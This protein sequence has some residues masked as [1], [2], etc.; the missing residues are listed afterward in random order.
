MSFQ[1]FQRQTPLTPRATTGVPNQLAAQLG[2]GLAIPLQIIS[3]T[4]VLR[5]GPAKVAQDIYICLSTPVGRRLWQPDYGS[6]LPYLIFQPYRDILNT[7]LIVATK[8]ALTAWVPQITVSQVNIDATNI[9]NNY[10]MLVIQY[11]I[12]GTNA[13]QQI[14][15]AL[16]MNDQIKVPPGTLTIGGQPLFPQ[17]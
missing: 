12:N 16:A 3:N 4:W 6:T 5:S 10:L 9:N 11:T 1:Y 14:K 13:P 15:I 8:T 7:E 17:S 2:S